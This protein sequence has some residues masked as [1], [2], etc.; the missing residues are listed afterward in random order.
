M[1]NTNKGD[2][3]QTTDAV[4]VT[5]TAK[6]NIEKQVERFFAIRFPNKDIEFEKECGYFG[7]W[8]SRFESGSPEKWADA[9]S[10]KAIKQVREEAKRGAN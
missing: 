4:G 5:E 2:T 3:L 6:L 10:L 1:E 9:E 7:E 8:V